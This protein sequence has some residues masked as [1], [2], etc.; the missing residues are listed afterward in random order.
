MPPGFTH[1]FLDVIAVKCIV[2]GRMPVTVIS[3][4]GVAGLLC[5]LNLCDDDDVNGKA[6]YFIC[7]G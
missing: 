7:G 5:E 3:A 6:K 2:R 4:D 1:S